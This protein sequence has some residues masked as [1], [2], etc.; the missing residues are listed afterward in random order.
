[1]TGEQCHVI[2]P[3]DQSRERKIWKHA[4][5]ETANEKQDGY[6]MM[7]DV[8]MMMIMMIKERISCAQ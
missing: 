2:V 6:K 5:I 7:D 4:L 8:M 3:D 1:V